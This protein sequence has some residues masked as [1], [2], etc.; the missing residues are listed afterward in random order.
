MQASQ[1]LHLAM[2]SRGLDVC[3]HPRIL[4]TS[5]Y[6]VAPHKKIACLLMQGFSV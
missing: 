2:F 4:E 6:E 1:Y 3:F 5:K